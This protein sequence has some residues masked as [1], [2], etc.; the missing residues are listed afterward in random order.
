MWF[1]DENI[2]AH[3]IG[4]SCFI[5][6]VLYILRIRVETKGHK[7]NSPILIIASASADA[8][9]DVSAAKLESDF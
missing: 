2:Q 5:Q 9:G 3:K 7:F 4:D 1:K 8:S 6:H